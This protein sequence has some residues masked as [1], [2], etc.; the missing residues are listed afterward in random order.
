MTS[1]TTL[2]AK[3]VHRQPNN[4]HKAVSDT[5]L[6]LKRYMFSFVIVSGGA[7][8]SLGARMAREPIEAL[9]GHGMVW[10]L[11]H[12]RHQE[13]VSALVAPPPVATGPSQ[14]GN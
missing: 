5:P 7:V 13:C 11:P 10:T 1:P 3:E 14:N 8:G 6:R 9:G 4:C 2:V 12:G